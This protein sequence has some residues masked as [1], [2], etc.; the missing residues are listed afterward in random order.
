MSNPR[1]KRQRRQDRKQD[2]T[3]ADRTQ[4]GPGWQLSKRIAL[5]PREIT[6]QAATAVARLQRIHEG[7]PLDELDV[8]AGHLD[9][10][11]GVTARLRR[12]ETRGRIGQCAHLAGSAFYWTPSRAH[13][14]VCASCIAAT[15]RPWRCD[16]CGRVDRQLR[17]W[18][19][20]AARPDR[21]ATGLMVVLFTCDACERLLTNLPARADE[22]EATA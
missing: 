13:A 6:L 10:A 21:T 22:G 9:F 12:N 14:V 20:A 5:G 4:L 3:R 19:V 15:P 8:R 7:A 16:R 18:I 17:R 11:S 2:Q 1:R